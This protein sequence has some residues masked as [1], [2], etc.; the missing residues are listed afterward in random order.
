MFKTLDSMVLVGKSHVKHGMLCQDRA[1]ATTIGNLVVL[2]VAD[3]MGSYEHSELGAEFAVNFVREHGKY[4]MECVE[5]D[6]WKNSKE[7][8]WASEDAKVTFTK[9]LRRFMFHLR[10]DLAEYTQRIGTV[11]DEAHSTLSFSLIDSEHFLNVSIGDSPLYTLTKYGPMFLDGNDNGK[12]RDNN[13]V[14]YSIVDMD[15]SIKAMGVQVGLT[16]DL[17]SVLITSDGAIGWSK[18]EV[19]LNK[20]NF[21]DLP[22]WYY[23]MLEGKRSFKATIEKLVEDGYDDVGIAYYVNDKSLLS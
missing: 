6:Q 5:L 7:V 4:P 22:D 11:P 15:Y 18:Q 23:E 3:G 2:A 14:T 10:D 20:E 8:T 9:E 19:L 16:K 12:E 17:R 1:I 13:N 21:G